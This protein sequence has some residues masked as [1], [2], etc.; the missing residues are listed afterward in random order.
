MKKLLVAFSILAASI[1]LMACAGGTP[2]TTAPV[3]SGVE[4]VTIFVGG[5]FDPL[6]GVSAIDDVDGNITANIRVSGTYNVDAPGTYF[7]RYV[8]EDAAGN[9][10]E[11]TRYLNVIIDPAL[12]GDALVPNGDFALGWAVWSA[13]TGIE[14]GNATYTVENG[15]LKVAISSVAGGM[16]EPRLENNGIPFEQGQIYQ[17][18]FDA[19]ADAP[20][21]IHVQVGELL[22][23]APWFTNFK[24]TTPVI[25]DLTSEMQTFTF[26]FRMDLEDNNN[27]SVLF[28]MGTVPGTVGTANLI[29]NVYLD[30]VVMTK[31]D[32]LVDTIA[33][34]LAGV[35][36][37]RI[38]LGSMFD[39]LE[40]VTVTDNVDGEIALSNVTVTG[41]VDVNTLGEYTLTYKVK[42]AAGNEAV[43]TRVITVGEAAAIDLSGNP[44][45]GWRFFVNDWEGTSGSLDVVEGEL[46]LTLNVLN[47]LDQNWKVQ[48]IQDAFAMGTGVDNEGSIQLEAGKTYR[49]TF[50]VRAS[51]AGEVTLAI[52]HGANGWVPYFTESFNVTTDMETITI[53]FTLDDDAIDYSVPAQFKFEFGLLFAGAEAPQTFTVD[54]VALEV[55]EGEAFVVTDLIVNGDFEPR[56]GLTTGWRAFTNSWEGTVGSLSNINEQLVLTLDALNAL[57]QNWKIQIIQD[58]FALGTGPDNAGSLQFEAGKTY[59]V[60]F[61]AKASVAGAAT[62]IIG[63]AGGGFTGYVVE[64]FNVTT[65][66]ET[67]TF[68]FTLDGD[69]DY[70]VLAQF[71]I[72]MGL[73]FAGLEGPQSFTLDNVKIEVSEAGEF[74]DANL[75]INGDFKPTSGYR[76][77]LNDWEGTSGSLAARNG[78]L[79]LTLDA[80]NALDQNWKIQIIQDAFALG[81]GPD[82]AGSLQFEAG[83]TYK[84]S[85]DAKASVA[86]AATFI[87]GHAGGGF[88]GY[89]V[90]AFNVTTELETYTFEFTLDGDLDYT[91]LAQFKIEMGLLFAGLEGPQSFSL[92]NISIEVSEDGDFVDAQIIV[93]GN[94]E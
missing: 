52:G 70:T 14:G 42:D 51:K 61:D 20:R 63:H 84:V 80:L 43:V 36:D 75:I 4:D 82:N 44:D 94:M 50:D 1:T 8:S 23:S 85:F 60:S 17:I 68:E 87:I 69:L 66:L 30:N 25:V 76:A 83:K 21:A 59:K 31:V 79:V 45:Y 89:V 38:G 28:E 12:L 29:T 57:D 72:E 74:V 11:S 64:A 5:T 58:A 2:D 24:P 49:A 77:F 10:S 34:V 46:V 16:W 26:S 48:I 93:N 73:L 40:G 18:S 67:Y 33:P 3:L 47:V 15:Q 62:F 35:A 37:G 78:L 27:G 6:A 92:G 65:E 86:G 88:T 71:K 39:P 91:V 13:T 54:N 55:Q 32:T 90:E 19:R 56:G 7:L 9:R 53:E 41:E 22:T 81:T